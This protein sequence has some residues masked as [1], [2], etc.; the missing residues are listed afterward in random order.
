[1]RYFLF[2]LVGLFCI[3]GCTNK[4][5]NLLKSNTAEVRE[6][7]LEGEEKGVKAN[8]VCGLREKEYKINGYATELIEFGVLTFELEN[9]NEYDTNLANFV[10][11]VGTSRYDGILERNPFNDTLVADIKTIIDKNE[12][13]VAKVIIGEFSQEIH[14]KPINKDWKIDSEDVYKIVADKFRKEINYLNREN[15][16]EAEVYIKILN[17]A[18]DYKGDYYWYVSII[19]RKGGTLSLIISPYSKD[20]LATNNTLQKVS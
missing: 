14:L 3:T 18:D 15:V 8:L 19:G 6:F 4:Y 1:M 16:F 11:L 7:M 12:N 10:L 5:E 17:D 9:I 13:I 20:V 2:F